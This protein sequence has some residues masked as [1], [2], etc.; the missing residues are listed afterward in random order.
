MRLKER[1]FLFMVDHKNKGLVIRKG[2]VQSSGMLR[3]LVITASKRVTSRL[4]VI[5]YK[6]RKREW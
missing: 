5:S 6:I 4:I 2:L 3:R 1:V